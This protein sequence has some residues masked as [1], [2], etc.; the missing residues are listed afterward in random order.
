MDREVWKDVVGYE[1]LYE[2][3]NL[4]RIKSKER[5]VKNNHGNRIVKSKILT[6]FI[7]NSGYCAIVLHNGRENFKLNYIHR[8][9]A[10]AF[11]DNKYNLEQVN[12]K[13]GNKLNNCVNNL[14]WCSRSDNIK[15]AIKNGF[16]TKEQVYRKFQKMMFKVKKP[17]L[18]IKNGVVIAEYDSATSAGKQFSKNAGTNI[19]SCARREIPTAYGFEWKYKV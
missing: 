17:I 9:V 3:S 14:E 4:G 8:L 12:H 10:N 5:I 7:T 15:H 13:D 16:I 19:S 11:L 1:G 2:V 18:Q 6:P